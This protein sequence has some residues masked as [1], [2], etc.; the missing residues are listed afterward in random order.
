MGI[1]GLSV[2]V[3]STTEYIE[4]VDMTGRH[5]HPTK[6]GRIRGKPP[7]ILARFGMGSS[8]WTDCVRALKPG[9][10][11]CR[12]IGSES[13]FLDKAAEIGQ[14]WL[15]GLGVVFA[16]ELSATAHP[17]RRLGALALA[18]TTC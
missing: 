3:L 6:R 7:V 13:A 9:E 8:E 11:F 15:R 16:L 14:C 1:R 2:T 10:G 5:W 4:L 18:G 12:V 17:F